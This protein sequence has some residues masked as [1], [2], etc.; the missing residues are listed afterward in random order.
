MQRK[1]FL[2]T[3]CMLAFLLPAKAQDSTMAAL[4]GKW[5]VVKLAVTVLTHPEG[6]PRE[7][8]ETMDMQRMVKAGRDV[9][10]GVTFGP[11]TYEAER[12]GAGER[13]MYFSAGVQVIQLQEQ[14]PPE[15]QVSASVK[16]Y[17]WRITGNNLILESGPVVYRDLATGKFVQATFVSTYSKN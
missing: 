17:K 10:T 6:L 9:L 15:V 1:Y 11:N 4:K 7:A 2:L 14:L 16:K 12:N 13:G 3:C 8:Y 5:T